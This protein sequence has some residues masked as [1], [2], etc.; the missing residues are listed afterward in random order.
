MYRGDIKMI[1][2]YTKN[3]DYDYTSILLMR[4]N[5]YQL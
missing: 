1:I 5:T 4:K 2:Y 3:E